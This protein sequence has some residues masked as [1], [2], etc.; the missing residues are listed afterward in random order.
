M[1][2]P[3]QPGGGM[4]HGIG[5]VDEDDYTQL[6]AAMGRPPQMI[7]QQ[8]SFPFQS[9]VG[10]PYYYDLKRVQENISNIYPAFPMQANKDFFVSGMF[11]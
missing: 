4:F 3:M 2:S 8:E 9:E 7:Q 6:P 1:M 5:S 11:N 10:A